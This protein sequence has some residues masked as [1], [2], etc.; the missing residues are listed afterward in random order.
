MSEEDIKDY[1]SKFKKKNRT[2]VKILQRNFLKSR[3]T[4]IMRQTK[5]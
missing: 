3:N 4:M 1:F 2:K 5:F